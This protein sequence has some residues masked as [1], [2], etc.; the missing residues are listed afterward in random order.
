MRELPPQLLDRWFPRGGVRLVRRLDGG[1]LNNVFRVETEVGGAYALRVAVPETTP[2]MV[3]WEHRLVT[4][5]G[6]HVP[7]VVA[8]LPSPEGGTRIVH[9]RR[10]TSLYPFVQGGPA[11]RRDPKHRT[12][13]AATLACI[14]RAA[15][16]APVLAP[17]PGHPALDDLQWRENRWWSWQRM[18]QDPPGQI[19]EN[20][21]GDLDVPAV[22]N[23]VAGHLDVLPRELRRIAQVEWPRHPLH[24]DYYEGNMRMQAGRVLGVFDW[25]ECRLDWRACEVGDAAWLFARNAESDDVDRGV[26]DDFVAAYQD[27]GGELTAAERALLPLLIRARRLWEALYGLGEPARGREVDWDY[28]AANLRAL[29]VLARRE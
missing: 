6:R 24:G 3:A 11:D 25:D 23:A 21:P 18:Q 14:H 7:E 16:S 26:F 12:A 5:L 8:P 10:V 29:E 22:L 4:H 20:R 1:Y 15:E 13:A 2:D 17:R 19:P 9:G 27:A 28:L